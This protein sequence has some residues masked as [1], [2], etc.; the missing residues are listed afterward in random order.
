VNKYQ[1]AK[2]NELRELQ[3]YKYRYMHSLYLYIMMNSIFVY[4]YFTSHTQHSS[5]NEEKIIC[6]VG[7]VVC[8]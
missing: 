4:L 2:M 3:N 8:N 6:K 7:L 5:F 1:F